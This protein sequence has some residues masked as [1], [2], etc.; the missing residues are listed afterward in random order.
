MKALTILS[1]ICVALAAFTFI[2]GEMVGGFVFLGFGM[3]G[4][5]YA[6]TLKR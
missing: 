6:A 5:A 1:W 3:A 4:I 2:A